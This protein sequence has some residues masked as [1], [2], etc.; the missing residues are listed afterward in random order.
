MNQHL[1]KEKEST[2]KIKLSE[3]KIVSV[4]IKSDVFIIS[5]GKEIQTGVMF[6]E[7]TIILN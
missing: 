1:V 7:N 4:D 5:D 2:V 3:D 6:M